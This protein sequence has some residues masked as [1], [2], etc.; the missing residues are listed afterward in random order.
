MQSARWQVVPSF[1]A[2]RQ[3]MS[4]YRLSRRTVIQAGPAAAGLALLPTASRAAAQDEVVVT[5]WNSTLPVEDANDL[6]KPLEDFYVYQAIARFEEANPGT[7]VEIETFPGGEDLFTKYRT[8]SVARN[9]PSVMGTW[10]GTYMLQFM[11]FL[12]PMGP[13]FTA[14][15]RAQLTGWEAVT[16]D[17]DAASPD[18]YGVPAGQ[19]GVTAIFYNKRLLADAG[20]DP[21]QDWPTDID[22]FFTFLDTLA[23]SGATPLALNE[24]AI[25]WQILLY[26]IGQTVGGA[27]GINALATGER[28]FSDPDL[29]DIIQ[30]W[31]GLYDYTVSGAETMQGSEASQLFVGE[32]AAMTTGLFGSIDD[33]R[34]PFGDDLGMIKL[35]NFS[36]DAPLLDG[37]I[38]GP[39]VAFIVSNYDP[40]IEAAVSFVKFLESP[41]ELELRAQSGEGQLVNLAGF[42]AATVYDDPFKIAQQEWTNEPSTIFWPDN[43]FPAEMTTEIK[44]QSQLAWTGEI[45]ATE[46]AARIDA[47]RDEVLGQ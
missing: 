18:I 13:H 1:A 43:I 17:F 33:L 47:K 38:G 21:E 34:V 46:F 6:T 30:R 4:P 22:G 39:G 36:A 35:P 2:R 14:D 24:N 44:A 3:I 41:A 16:P 28:S 32:E 40:N 31:Q 15:E 26:W 11:E 10:S 19:D 8:A 37:G 12:E 42:D 7:K 25:I 20:L 29:V 23:G 27:P 5:F 45:D 9:G